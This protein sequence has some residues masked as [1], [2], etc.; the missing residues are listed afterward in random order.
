VIY[1]EMDGVGEV[2]Y[3]LNEVGKENV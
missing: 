2:W 1:H 3:L